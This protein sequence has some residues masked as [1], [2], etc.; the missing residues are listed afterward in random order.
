MH[1][2]WCTAVEPDGRESQSPACDKRSILYTA[3]V[4]KYADSM[5][6]RRQPR[7]LLRPSEAKAGSG[8]LACARTVHPGKAGQREKQA[9]WSAQER[10]MSGRQP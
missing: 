7:T 6:Y 10:S 8:C 2:T 9:A 4:G 3:I 5:E 1:S